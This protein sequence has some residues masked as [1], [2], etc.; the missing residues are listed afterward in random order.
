MQSLTL[1]IALRPTPNKAATHL[2]LNPPCPNTSPACRLFA[3]AHHDASI[4]NALCLL[5]VKGVTKTARGTLWL[6]ACGRTSRCGLSTARVAFLTGPAPATM[7]YP[8]PLLPSHPVSVPSLA[9]A[10]RPQRADRINMTAQGRLRRPAGPVAPCGY[11]KYPVIAER[12]VDCSHIRPAPATPWSPPQGRPR[13]IC[14]IGAGDGDG[15]AGRSDR[16]SQYSSGTLPSG[17]NGRSTYEMSQRYHSGSHKGHGQVK[18][19]PRMGNVRV[20]GGSQQQTHRSR[21]AVKRHA[22]LQNHVTGSHTH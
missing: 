13:D 2:L 16:M 22:S 10:S 20:T 18:R 15:A 1:V 12:S 3:R 11:R 8:P 4:A 17:Y 7:N 6:D 14:N 9:M 21:S 19:D 5:G